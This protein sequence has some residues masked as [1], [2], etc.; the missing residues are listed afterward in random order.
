[1]SPAVAAGLGLGAVDRRPPR[2]ALYLEK[3]RPG[4]A[5]PST[6][7]CSARSAAPPWSFAKEAKGG[8]AQ[9]GA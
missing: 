5:T 8:A 2:V 7:A 3:R 1:M 6:A 4:Q 9:A